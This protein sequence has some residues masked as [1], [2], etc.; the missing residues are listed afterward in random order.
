MRIPAAEIEQLV[1]GEIATLFADPLDFA[2]RT[3][4]VLAP[5]TLQPFMVATKALH[6]QAQDAPGKLIS[7]LV[8]Q[9]RVLDDR[10]EVV[11]ATPSLAAAVKLP[12]EADAP[13]SIVL[14]S[15]VRLTRAGRAIRLVHSGGEPAMVAEHDL[16]LIRLVAKA[17]NWWA[18]IA[19]G[20]IT[21][22]ELAQQERVTVQRL[23]RVIRLAFLSR[24]VKEALVAGKLAAGVNS[25]AL[26][27]IDAI[28]HAWTD[29]TNLLAG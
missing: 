7:R 17:Q 16:S 20:E 25:T 26:L 1:A 2:E 13:A 5:A 18:I 27:T 23:L 4:L 29:Q 3:Q 21:P 6:A 11:F 9:V 8:D 24:A 10:I 14:T 19:L 15:A 22:A 28:A 12:R